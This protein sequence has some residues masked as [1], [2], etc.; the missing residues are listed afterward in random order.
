M[1]LLFMIQ[2]QATVAK[3]DRALEQSYYDVRKELYK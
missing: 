3:H 1:T 2:A